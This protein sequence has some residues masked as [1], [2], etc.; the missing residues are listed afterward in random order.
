[1]IFNI[2]VTCLSLR[3]II[4]NLN[5]TMPSNHRLRERYAKISKYLSKH[6]R[7]QPECLGLEILPGG[8]VNVD[9]VLKSAANNGFPISIPDLHQVVAT[10]DKQRFAFDE[11]GKF[12]RANQGHSTPVDLQLQPQNPPNILYHGSPMGVVAEILANGIDKM[13]RHHVHL[14]ADVKLA[15]KVGSRRGKSAVFAID[16]GTMMTDGYQFYCTANNVWL[17]DRVPP[18]YLDLLK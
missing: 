1:L 11:S 8:W 10:N 12:I 2:F 15:D 6:L 18:R 9:T 7:Y 4:C 14:T 16:T 3:S 17:V 13:S 5:I